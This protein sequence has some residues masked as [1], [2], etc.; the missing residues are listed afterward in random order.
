MRSNQRPRSTGSPGLLPSPCGRTFKGIKDWTCISWCPPDRWI[1]FLLKPT[2]FSTSTGKG[3]P[4]TVSRGGEEAR[5][6]K[7][8]IWGE[9]SVCSWAKCAC[10]TLSPS[11]KGEELVRRG[12]KENPWLTGTSESCPT[13]SE[14][15]GQVGEG[16]G[17]DRDFLTLSGETWLT[18]LN[19]RS[20]SPK[21][22]H[23][24]L[25]KMQILRLLMHT[26]GI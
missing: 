2:P 9:I 4:G 7:M 8:G 26:Y 25:F 15:Q 11:G 10:P 23:W 1:I 3:G 18:S 12:F 16:V 19:Q 21:E 20:S 13:W 22:S 17:G 24:V 5:R 14:S 6:A